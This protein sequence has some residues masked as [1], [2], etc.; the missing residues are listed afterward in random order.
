MIDWKAIDTEITG[1]AQYFQGCLSNAAE[2]SEAAAK[3]AGY[4]GTLMILSMAVK[5]KLAKEDDGK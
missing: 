4:I 3:F 1:M 5:E 2:G